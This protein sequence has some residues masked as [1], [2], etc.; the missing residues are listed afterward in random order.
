M[1]YMRFTKDDI[2]NLDMEMLL[3][4]ADEKGFVSREIGLDANNIVIYKSPTKKN[5]YGLFDNQPIA[6]SRLNNQL[7]EVEFDHYWSKAIVN[8]KRE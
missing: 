1:F 2:K 8:K 3:I 7:T 4:E 6:I 5:N